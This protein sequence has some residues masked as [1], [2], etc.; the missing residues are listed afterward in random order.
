M[1]QAFRDFPSR[2]TTPVS[3]PP[4][5]LTNAVEVQRVLYENILAGVN[6][7]KT[8]QQAMED[9]EAAVASVIR[10]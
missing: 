5:R 10:T 6:G 1:L 7:R 2:G 9:A 4:Y 8:P 3:I